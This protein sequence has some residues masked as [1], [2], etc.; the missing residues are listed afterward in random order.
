[1][2]EGVL[3]AETDRVTS[4]ASGNIG[5]V[6]TNI[7]NVVVGVDKTGSLSCGLVNVVDEAVRWVVVGEEIKLVEESRPR[8]VLGQAV[9]GQRALEEGHCPKESRDANHGERLCVPACC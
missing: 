1:M 9:C 2:C 6:N 7:S 4:A 8:V 3:A 5:G